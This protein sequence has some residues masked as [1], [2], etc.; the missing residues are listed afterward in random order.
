[1]L[2][3]LASQPSQERS[4]AERGMSAH[5]FNSHTHTDTHTQHAQPTVELGA[6]AAPHTHTHTHTLTY[7]VS[8]FTN[9]TQRMLRTL[10]RL[11]PSVCLYVGEKGGKEENSFRTHLKQIQ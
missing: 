7:L 5:V 6:K 2:H 4:K 11:C 10:L 8:L 1:M 3:C 9:C